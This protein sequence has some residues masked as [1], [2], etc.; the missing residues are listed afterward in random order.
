[1]SPMTPVSSEAPNLWCWTTQHVFG[2]M[3]MTLFYATQTWKCDGKTWK[4]F[5][6]YA[7]VC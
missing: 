4:I 7:W 2:T 6:P 1:V 3:A 5:T